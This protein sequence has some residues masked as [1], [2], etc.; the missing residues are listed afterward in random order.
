[1]VSG[2][3]SKGGELTGCGDELLGHRGD[4]SLHALLGRLYRRPHEC[5]KVRDGSLKGGIGSSYGRIGTSLSASL[6]AGLRACVSSELRSCEA[7]GLCSSHP[8]S[9]ACGGAEA[10][11]GSGERDERD[12]G[13][14]S[15]SEGRDGRTERA[16]R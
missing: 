3:A 4:S 12:G 6:S 9:R 5:L 11:S 1:M 8:S 7:T 13:N 15:G 16:L 2:A 14:R 10:L